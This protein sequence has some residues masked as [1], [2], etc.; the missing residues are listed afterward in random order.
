MTLT[1]SLACVKIVDKLCF[2]YFGLKKVI[3][4][5]FLMEIDDKT[6]FIWKKEGLRCNILKWLGFCSPYLLMNLIKDF[7]EPPQSSHHIQVMELTISSIVGN[8]T[9]NYPPMDHD[10]I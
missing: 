5:F 8:Q 10:S 3:H 9:R 7:C 6:P 4:G 1:Y 2:Q